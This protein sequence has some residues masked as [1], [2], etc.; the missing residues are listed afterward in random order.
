MKVRPSVK[1]LC[2]ACKIVKRKNVV[3]V[4]C[5]NPRHKQRQGLAIELCMPRLLGVEIPADKRIEASLTYIYGIGPSTAKRVLEQTNIDPNLRAKDLTPQQI[6]EIIQTITSE[7]D[8]DR[9]RSAPRSAE[10]SEA[11]AGDQLLSRRSASPRTASARP[12]HVDQCAHAQGSAQDGGCH[13]Q[14]GRKGRQGLI[15]E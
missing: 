10:Q 7:Q 5:K 15:G 1:R 13:S 2:E 4:I 14:Q 3:R 12:A 6:N 8:Y 11:F 9:R